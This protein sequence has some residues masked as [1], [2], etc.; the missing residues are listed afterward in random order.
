MRN[1]LFLGEL[2]STLPFTH[3]K[4]G[5]LDPALELLRKYTGATHAYFLT[6]E[7]CRTGSG[8]AMPTEEIPRRL[9]AEMSGKASTPFQPGDKYTLTGPEDGSPRTLVAPVYIGNTMP[10]A[11]VLTGITALAPEAGEYVSISV[12]II[13][14]WISYNNKTRHGREKP[15]AYGIM[16][17]AAGGAVVEERA[18]YCRGRR[19]LVVD[20][21]EILR[22]LI[23]HVLLMH[24]CSVDMAEDGGQ[25]FDLA[26]KTDYD[27]IITDLK[28]P[29]LDGHGMYQ[30][31][32]EHRPDLAGRVVF[33]TGDTADGCAVDILRATGRPC[34]E[35]PFTLESIRDLLAGGYGEGADA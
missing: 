34:L 20:D 31:L 29:G 14:L 2:V 28:M 8:T 17:K 27:M 23:S 30:M 18:P 19:I 1:P 24:G 16:N 12:D 3:G 32:K 7:D 25:G 9:I 15:Y 13:A 35:K 26:L 33:T 10:G 11:V 5:N 6:E 21:E 22:E 4:K